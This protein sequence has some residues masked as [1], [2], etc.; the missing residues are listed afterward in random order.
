MELI[1]ESLKRRSCRTQK[2]KMAG[3][4]LR[5]V[6]GFFVAWIDYFCWCELRFCLCDWAEET[7]IS[8]QFHCGVNWVFVGV[9]W[10]FVCE[11]PLSATVVKS[12]EVDTDSRLPITLHNRNHRHT[13]VSAHKSARVNTIRLGISFKCNLNGTNVP[14][15][16]W[17]D[18]S[19]YLD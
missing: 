7:S 6:N 2:W 4:S 12:S 5:S 17:L 15:Y 3:K 16:I 10:D 14:N 1:N 13:P 9:N 8:K 11:W 18:V 19:N